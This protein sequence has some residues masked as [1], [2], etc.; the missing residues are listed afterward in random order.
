MESVQQHADIIYQNAKLLN[1]DLKMIFPE[2]SV[3][4]GKSDAKKE[5][6][7][8]WQDFSEKSDRYV[9]AAETFKALIDSDPSK[10]EVMN[11]FKEMRKACGSCHLNYKADD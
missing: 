10:Q 9:T 8:H 4:K 1:K 2:Q 3:L 6:W 11:G 5:I 7:M